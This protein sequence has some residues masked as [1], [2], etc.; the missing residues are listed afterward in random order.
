MFFRLSS[1][2][3]IGMGCLFADAA[4]TDSNQTKSQEQIKK[5]MD[6]WNIIQENQTYFTDP[7]YM[8]QRTEKSETLLATTLANNKVLS[9]KEI[10]F[11]N[12]KTAKVRITMYSSPTCTHCA[13]FHEKDLAKLTERTKSGSL[14]LVMRTFIANLKYDLTACK[15]TWALGESK[16]HELMDKM[17]KAQKEW[18]V[19]TLQEDYPAKLEQKLQ[20][21][22]QKLNMPA[23]DLRLRLKI[24]TNKD[25][26]DVCGLLKLY[27]LTDLGVDLPTLEKNISDEA[28]ERELLQM[29]LNATESDGKYLS[30]TPAFYVQT[31][32]QKLFDQGHLQEHT[33]TIEMIDKLIQ[34][35]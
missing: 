26:I 21:V 5:D 8:V 23:D 14:M 16:Q 17:L 15:I 27:A 31:D 13:E 22:S 20:E 4:A 18:L 28:L 19:P 2:L 34:G 12:P 33:P 25:K 35:S 24:E 3:I 9:L 10:T 11:G 32:S 6:D 30:F 1:F 7:N 29:S